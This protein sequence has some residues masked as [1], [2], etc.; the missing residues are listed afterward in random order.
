M[1]PTLLTSVEA[2]ALSWSGT[3]GMA[4]GA[5]QVDFNLPPGRALGTTGLSV[6]AQRLWFDAND[7][8]LGGSTVSAI[9]GAVTAGADD[10]PPPPLARLR[11]IRWEPGGNPDLPGP[12][13]RRS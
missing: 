11:P 6:F 1:A 10:A 8:S 13:V 12:S 5:V 4:A 7:P 3:A 9:H 2:T